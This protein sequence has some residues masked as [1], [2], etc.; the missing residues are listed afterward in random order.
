MKPFTS[1]GKEA[2]LCRYGFGEPGKI[3]IGEPG[4]SIPLNASPADDEDGDIGTNPAAGL[5]GRRG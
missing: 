5:I 2:V 4:Y 3:G 1:G